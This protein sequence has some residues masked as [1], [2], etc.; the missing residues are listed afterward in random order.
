LQWSNGSTQSLI[1]DLGPGTYTVTV[2]DAK[3][4]QAS[5]AHVVTAPEPLILQ[6]FGYQNT[7]CANVQDGSVSIGVM[8]GNEPYRY[9]WS[10]GHSGPSL[11]NV[12]PGEYRI[13]VIDARGCAASRSVRFTAPEP[14]QISLIELR[15]A[16]CNRT[17]LGLINIRTS[18]G[19]GRLSYLWSNG[20]I[21]E[22]IVEL[23]A[24]TYTVQVFDENG[25]SAM[26]SYTVKSRNNIT[27][28]IEGPTIVCINSAPVQFTASPAGGRFEGAFINSSGL[29]NTASARNGVYVISYLGTFEGCPYRAERS[30]TVANGPSG[31]QIVFNG[32]VLNSTCASASSPLTLGVVPPV[33]GVQAQFSGVGVA[34]NGFVPSNAGSGTHTVTAVLTDASTGCSRT[35]THNITVDAPF[36]LSVNQ[37][38]ATICNGQPVLLLA[39]GATQYAWEPVN[40]L[41]CAP[42]CV[43]NLQTVSAAPGSS[44][45]Y[46]VTGSKGGCTVAQTIAVTVRNTA[47]IAI[48]GGGTFCSGVEQPLE[49]S[50]TA[51]YAYTWTDASN[52]TVGTGARILFSTNQP[53]TLTVTGVD[54][55]GCRQ[56]ARVTLN[57]IA[58]SVSVRASANDICPNTPV[59]LIVTD[60]N[61]AG[62]YSWAPNEGLSAI[63]GNAVIARPTQTTTYTVTR[64]GGAGACNTATVTVRVRAVEPATIIGLGDSYCLSSNAVNVSISPTTGILTG[65]GIVGRTFFPALAGI[66]RHVIRLSGTTI[67]GCSYVQTTIIEVRDVQPATIAN[68]LPSYCTLS[69]PVVL[70]AE[71]LGGTFSGPGMVGNIFNPASAGPGTHS[72]RY[73]GSLANGCRFETV[74]QV[75][76][77]DVTPV[78]F[79]T[80]SVYCV[81][82]GAVRLSASPAGGTFSGTGVVDG[83]FNPSIAGLG[84]HMITYSGVQGPCAYSHT[85]AVRVI[86]PMSVQVVPTGV[87]CATCRDGQVQVAVTGQR[88]SLTYRLNDGEAQSSPVFTGLSAGTYTVRVVDSQ[89]CEWME[90]VTIGE[91]GCAAPAII[92]VNASATAATITWTA[93]PGVSSYE[94]AWRNSPTGAWIIVSVSGT[95]FSLTGLNPNTTHEVQIRSRCG[96]VNSQFSAT[97]TFNTQPA[98]CLA[99]ALTQ[100]QVATNALTVSWSATSPTAEYILSYREDRFGAAWVSIPVTG[101][102][103][104]VSGL[105]A[106]TRY[107][108]R[109]RARC[110]AN[111]SVFSDVLTASTAVARMGEEA[112]NISW[113]VYPNPA[114]D[115]ISVSFESLEAGNCTIALINIAGQ[116][117]FESARTV[118]AG[119]QQW[120]I[121]LPFLASGAYVLRFSNGA[122]VKQ[123]KLLIE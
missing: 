60:V 84:E 13:D 7:T 3:G 4:C 86:A 38:A 17:D 91:G 42:N 20:V 43:G 85:V 10:N 11:Q 97:T 5:R 81:N 26:A 77:G 49:A 62:S 24:G 107:L 15:D 93:V 59:S 66:G 116:T 29:F 16:S 6:T 54:A 123:M 102:R 104:T 105:N 37:S 57:P 117:V 48:T 64:D 9:R 113:T 61:P 32:Q 83:Q 88:G 30:I 53:T 45:T 80:P 118:D 36:L 87:S 96:V 51:D 70:T 109:I 92:Q 55:A 100:E 14:I 74:R 78:V 122:Q 1:R 72:I 121:D 111:L 106:G 25:C 76:V 46:T 99:P 22:D 71:P 98:A 110:G 89:G 82:Q 69:A 18:G 63:T 44:I 95:S 40:G 112:N 68:L 52:R 75:S 31:G 94:L 19:Q 23:V 8:G 119:A 79:N 50:S 115:H 33:P 58:N 90:Q 2:T 103:F 47:P 39:S 120:A 27:P 12:G 21:S 101:T 114:S 28:T 34:G 67:S 56:T 35:I 65:P 108:V 41:N 73:S